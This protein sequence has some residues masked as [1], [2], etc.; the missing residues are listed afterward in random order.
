MPGHPRYYLDEILAWRDGRARAEVAAGAF[1]Q[2]HAEARRLL[3]EE[4]HAGCLAELDRVA[5][6]KRDAGKVRLAV[7]FE[8]LAA[9]VRAAGPTVIANARRLVQRSGQDGDAK[10]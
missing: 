7:V 4:S 3:D 1:L 9:D 2:N 8:A 10:S 5:K 6:E